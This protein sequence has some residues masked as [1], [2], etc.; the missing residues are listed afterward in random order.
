MKKIFQTLFIFLTIGLFLTS[1]HDYEESYSTIPT[2][3]A[4]TLRSV[5]VSS[6]VFSYG[7]HSY[8]SCRL[9]VS[10]NSDMSDAVECENAKNQGVAY[11]LKANTTY[12]AQYT[13]TQ[14]C[15][16]GEAMIKS[17]IT[18]FKTPA[19]E[20][21]FYTIYMSSIPME[22]SY[23]V[24]TS[25]AGGGY[26]HEK[27]YVEKEMHPSA[28][29]AEESQVYVYA[30]YASGASAP[31]SVPVVSG[32]DFYYGSGTVT[33]DK[34]TV[35]V[36]PKRFTAHVNVN[37]TFKAA[38]EEVE[39]LWLGEIHMVNVSGS[40]P[41]CAN[42]TLNLTT[43]EFTPSATAAS[44]YE[45]GKDE[46]IKNGTTIKRTFA[47]VLPVKFD[48]NTVKVVLDLFGDVKEKEVS[49][50]LPASTWSEG[51]DVNVNLSAEYT[52]TGVEL[53]IGYVEVIPWS[54]GSTGNIDITK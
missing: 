52:A 20:P 8:A 12:Y 48:E 7:Y 30:P 24:F 17:P 29:I 33:P 19:Y 31:T 6:A 34:P 47:G 50:N 41:L 18:E 11:G 38:K 54:E 16:E 13:V 1:C 51:S 37:V 10:P 28:K 32:Q 9:Y 45:S 35:S 42:G 3:D 40:S 43:G 46:L 53:Y 4:P 15:K 27:I 44:N 26:S 14:H 21:T 49:I 36:T 22:G 25:N 39:D 5:T 2:L 23:G